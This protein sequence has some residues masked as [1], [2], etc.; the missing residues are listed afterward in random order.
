[1]PSATLRACRVPMSPA[2]SPGDLCPGGPLGGFCWDSEQPIAH[3]CEEKTGNGVK[4]SVPYGQSYGQAGDGQ[5]AL[6]FPATCSSRPH[7][8]FTSKETG[9]NVFTLSLAGAKDWGIS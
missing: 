8:E 1:M 5:Q 4:A 7:C 3:P 2:A 6:R 9:D